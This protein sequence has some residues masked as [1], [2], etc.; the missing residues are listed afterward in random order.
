MSQKRNNR[1][2]RFCS[3]VLSL[4]LAS[5]FGMAL[6]NE[7]LAVDGLDSLAG[8]EVLAAPVSAAAEPVFTLSIRTTSD[9]L[10]FLLPTSSYLNSSNS[11][12]AYDWTIN[13]GDGSTQDSSGFSADNS[14]IPHT[15]AGAGDYLISISPH[16]EQEAWLAA[17]GF[18]VN[19]AGA[20]T[21]A[22][23]SMVTAILSP[24]TPELTRTQ[25]QIDG[26]ASAPMYEWAYSFCFCYNLTTAP[27]FSGWQ[28]IST[29][30]GN[31][32][33]YMF[34]N[35]T[36]L[37]TLP[38]GFNLPQSF[39]DVG[40]F[41]AAYMFTECSA[42]K[43]LPDGFSFPAGVTSA[44]DYFAAWM[45][46]NCSSLTTLPAG[47]NFPQGIV[48]VGNNFASEMFN[49][50]VSL[51]VLPT[52]CTLPQSMTEAGQ[53]FAYYMFR[54][55]TAL[56]TLPTGF[57]LPKALTS[58][59]PYF[60][61]WMFNGCSSLKALPAGFN[62][63]TGLSSADERFCYG[64]F[65]GCTSLETLSSGFNLPQSLTSTDESFASRMFYNCTSLVT[66]PA[67]FSLPKNL[68]SVGS[69]FVDYMFYN[70]TSLTA[71]PAGF[72]F[73]QG[74]SSVGSYF[75]TGTFYNCTS[76]VTLPTGFNL[77]QGITSAGDYFAFRLFC[78]CSSL[79][80]LPAGFNL[81]QNLSSV[82][83]DFAADFLYL[84]G[85]PNFQINAEFRFPAGIAAGS[86]YAFNRAMDIQNSAPAQTRTAAS[87]IGSCPTPNSPRATFDGHYSDLEHIAVNWGGEGLAPIVGPPRSG[88]LNGDGYV[89][90]NEVLICAQA[91][92]GDIGLNSD[93]LAAID[94]D[95][96]GFIT[97][98]DVM[99]VYQ[100]A[101]L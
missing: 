89:T 91:A 10:T 1:T 83:S 55:C 37:E 43:S 16:G 87:I 14:G 85:G 74:L 44:G 50:C 77:P 53:S 78:T 67:G 28:G 2:G 19:V 81:P 20:N 54:G 42:L 95:G 40:D 100:M 7:L 70:C 38:A 27:I 26:T 58:A 59:G 47:F 66:L 15:Y 17:F 65:E 9:S 71:L 33:L 76:L 46:L 93:Q 56:E 51:Q 25:D 22:N 4:L 39:T 60:A 45:F 21:L 23:K 41:F 52:G 57:S 69:S 86:S 34:D 92:L 61:Y 62:L 64:M 29:V 98:A 48:S 3:V 30:G 72:S 35:C 5:A 12:K 82:G 63:P 24:V 75:A 90:M 8:P 96:D 11:V 84:S 80:P 101:I 73:P 79:G 88:D 97:M 94:M 36:S 13:W 32:A 18:S 68:T 6:P 99:R 31:F 49:G